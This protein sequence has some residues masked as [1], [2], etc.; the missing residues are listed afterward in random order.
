MDWYPLIPDV[1]VAFFA[2]V[3]GAVLTVIIARVAYREE[4]RRRNKQLVRNLAD[5][6]SVRR[7][8]EV[9]TP[10]VSQADTDDANRC[11]RSVTAAQSQISAIRD[12]IAPDHELRAVLQEMVLW[13][14]EYK[15]LTEREPER[16]Q[17][18]LMT[19]RAELVDRVR[20]TEELLRLEAGSLPEP[21]KALNPPSRH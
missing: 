15:N 18:S 13:C 12:Q 7:A 16:W 14:R 6:L 20:E 3:L 11:F 9:I 19:V 2:A 5:E 8:F 1:V 17:F 4:Q 21:G 10:L